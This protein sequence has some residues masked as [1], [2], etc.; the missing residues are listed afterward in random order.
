MC[1]IK[2]DV[3]KDEDAARLSEY[4]AKYMP[5]PDEFISALRDFIRIEPRLPSP[6]KNY[7]SSQDIKLSVD[8]S[9]EDII[10]YLEGIRD[11]NLTADLAFYAYRD[12]KRIEWE[13]FLAACIERSPVA[14]ELSAELEDADA[15]Y[16]WLCRMENKSIYGDDR[17]AH[18]D[19]VVN[20]H[21]GDGIEKAITLADILYY[22]YPELDIKIEIDRSN[23]ALYHNGIEY[24]FDSAKDLVRT[25]TIEP[26]KYGRPTVTN[27]MQSNFMIDEDYTPSKT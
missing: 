10:E 12:M 19:E 11:N 4:L 26:G 18:P 24:D 1:K 20:Y 21:R 15:V 5:E 13:P 7:I 8:S 16:Q 2:I 22:R 9:R 3:H 17:L 6:E 14:I 27:Q 25:I 23:V